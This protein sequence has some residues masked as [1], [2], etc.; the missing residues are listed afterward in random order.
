[1]SCKIAMPAE[2]EE[3][4]PTIWIADDSPLEAQLIVRALGPEYRTE[5]FG[6]GSSLLERLA[7]S[8]QRPDVVLLDWVMPGVSGEEVCRFLRARPETADLSIILVTASRVA[9]DDVVSGLSAGADDYVSKPFAP[10]ELR[11]RVSTI[12]RAQR[13]REAE[14]RQS[15]RLQ[16]VV[17]LAK[18]LA[19][20]G[21]SMQAVLDALSS[22]LVTVLG[23]GCLIWTDSAGAERR[24]HVDLPPRCARGGDAAR[25]AGRLAGSWRRPALPQAGAAADPAVFLARRAEGPLALVP[26]PVSGAVRRRRAPALAAE[27][28]ERR[29]GHVDYVAGRGAQELPEGRPD[30]PGVV[31]GL[32][33]ADPGERAAL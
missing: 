19:A 13:L 17:L 15:R 16:L 25:L 21:P 8:R 4:R 20:A 26:A 3:S 30:A 18:R 31:P 14:K 6:D 9:V 1:M 27:G 28:P 23:D 5:V 32:W 29:A 12:L 33:R 10:E 24:L 22:T 2:E 7:G 11:A